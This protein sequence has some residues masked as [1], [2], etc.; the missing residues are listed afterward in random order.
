M[1]IY[2]IAL[3]GIL[4]ISFIVSSWWIGERKKVID[5]F[6]SDVRILIV[7]ILIISF[8][9]LLFSL[10][11]FNLRISII[12]GN[13]IYCLTAFYF[14][15]PLILGILLFAFLP[16]LCEMG[17]Q[18]KEVPDHTLVKEITC[19]LGLTTQPT[20][21]ISL[22]DVPPA[23]YGRTAK[24]SVLVLPG[25]FESILDE[26]EQ[27]AVVAHELSHI[28]QGDIGIFTWLTL[29]MKGFSYWIILFPVTAYLGL[30]HRM[31]NP[32]GNTLITV[33]IPVLFFSLVLFKN[34]L[35]RIRESIAD[36]YVVFHGFEHFLPTAI[37][38]FA[39]KKAMK[40]NIF[41]FC[42][43]RNIQSDIKIFNVFLA[44]HPSIPKRL[45][46][47]KNKIFLVEN[48]T[49]LSPQM[50][51][52]AGIA[53]AMLF[54]T[55]Y[56]S[57]VI[58]T[59]IFD[60]SVDTM[61][62]TTLPVLFFA[63]GSI[64]AFLYIFPTTKGSMYFFDMKKREFLIPFL[65]NVTLTMVAGA[66]VYYMLSFDVVMVRIFLSSIVLGLALWV[67]GF[68]SSRPTDFSAGTAYLVFAPLLWIGMLW[69]PVH[70]IYLSFY[71]S[72]GI[73][74]LLVSLFGTLLLILT[75]YLIFELRGW[76]R[77][78][79]KEKTLKIFTILK[80]M[81]HINNAIFMLSSMV[82]PFLV[83][84]LGSLGIFGL[85]CFIG[86]VTNPFAG[87]IILFG[88]ISVLIIY[89][90]K[91]SEILFFLEI[92]YLV[93]IIS[94]NINKRQN[95][96]I[97]SVIQEYQSDDGGFDYGGIGF[98]N[99]RDVFYCIKTV[100]MISSPEPEG[101]LNWILSTEKNG[102]F[103]LYPHGLP[104]LEATFY[105]LNTLSVMGNLE[106]TGVPLDIHAEWV[107]TFFNGHY[108]CCEHDTRS[109]L[110]QTCY[111]VDSLKLLGAL[112]KLKNIDQC[113]QWINTHF[114]ETS[115]PK[116][117]YFTLKTLHS[118]GKN[119]KN[120][121]KWIF[122]NDISRFRVDKNIADIYYYIKILRILHK[123][124]PDIVLK[125]AY[126]QL[127]TIVKKY[128]NISENTM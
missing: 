85:S 6:E 18:L 31:M 113:A 46:N 116:T 65:R 125:Q 52:W 115:D 41:N 117:A 1:I 114:S 30:T 39:S 98:S 107:I 38:K 35:S 89:G 32:S 19:C 16:H 14:L 102:G 28:K 81:P 119:L 2:S 58:L 96:F 45:Y 33:L 110:L 20:V 100:N 9:F 126:D 57:A 68:S 40:S 79:I 50:A 75:L 123:E 64:V 11:M 13:L 128:Y 103:A 80:E 49:N 108:F 4:S 60:I 61:T 88:I 25:N 67:M 101:I 12:G 54:F 55:V 22:S 118:L 37:I 3:V 122:A 43:H 15:T 105:A 56:Y 17:L 10:F 7:I 82:A 29:L 127:R 27:R 63:S 42:F 86:A 53:P 59:T 93:D 106:N 83:P 77:I 69:Y 97:Q 62:A 124:V 51:V 73:I 95:Q 104:R 99:Q 8:Y 23:T 91:Q 87:W 34:S 109:I 120:G 44:T 48:T 76:V 24:S 112:K 84:V 92:A 121:E 111:A 47:I 70:F 78:E 90:V 72:M 36:A 26:N 66:G 71:H 74:H 21:K 94:G 5:Q